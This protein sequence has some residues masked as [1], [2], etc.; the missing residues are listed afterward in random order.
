MDEE[1]ERVIQLIKQVHRSAPSLR[2][3][4]LIVNALVNGESVYY[5]EDSALGDALASYSKSLRE[6]TE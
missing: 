2:V 1:V 6:R 5:V 4:Q 3:G